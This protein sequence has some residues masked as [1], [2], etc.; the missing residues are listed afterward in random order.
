MLSIPG[1][2]GHELQ[3]LENVN[4]QYSFWSG[5]STPKSATSLYDK[6]YRKVF[7]QAGIVDAGLTV[8]GTC[9]RSGHRLRFGISHV[10]TYL[11]HSIR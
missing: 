1:R 2:V 8:S 6:L 5:E 4:R 11:L 7:R 10:F 9:S 3:Q